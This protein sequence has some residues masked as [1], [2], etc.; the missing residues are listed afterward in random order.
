MVLRDVLTT[1][2]SGRP[3]PVHY[4]ASPRFSWLTR[5]AQ[6][7]TGLIARAEAPRTFRG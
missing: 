6:D 4:S 1:P 5:Q 2:A 7:G 3:A